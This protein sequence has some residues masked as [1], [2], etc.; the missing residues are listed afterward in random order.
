[1]MVRRRPDG[2]LET[3]VLRVLWRATSPMSPGEV[4]DALGG[5]LAYTT[6]MTV[7]TRLHEKRLVHRSARGRAFEYG[8]AVTESELTARRMEEALS[9]TDDR[10]GALSGFVGR[11]SK[12]DIAM[13]RRAMGD[14]AP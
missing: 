6:V 3:E 4:R 5:D 13:L 14:Q 9:T 1:M 8:S 2:A 11:L 12:R 7:L 10:A